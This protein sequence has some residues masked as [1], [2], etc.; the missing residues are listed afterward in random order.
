MDNTSGSRGSHVRW[1]VLLLLCL[2]YLVTYLDRVSL[3]ITA[4]RIRSN[5][6][7]YFQRLH[8]GLRNI[9]GAWWLAGRPVW[10]AESSVGHHGLPDGGCRANFGSFGLQ[11]V[12]GYSFRTGRG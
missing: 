5:D 12:L 10:P 8:L 7:L 3:G 9:P 2:M 11:I 4:Q 1:V 6:G